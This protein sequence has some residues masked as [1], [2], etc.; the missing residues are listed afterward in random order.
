MKRIYTSIA[1]LALIMTSLVGV[2][3]AANATTLQVQ[4]A[5][6]GPDGKAMTLVFNHD[7][8]VGGA[9]ALVNIVTLRVNASV[10]S[11]SVSA[12]GAN[13]TVLLSDAAVPGATVTISF[14]NGGAYQLQKVGDPTV[15]WTGVPV[16]VTNN[17]VRL[18]L[19]GDTQVAISGQNELSATHPTYSNY[20]GN[21]N[22]DYY[23][24]VSDPVINSDNAKS[25]YVPY[26]NGSMDW[27]ISG[28]DDPTGSGVAIGSASD[29]Y[30]L[31]TQYSTTL[32]NTAQWQSVLVGNELYDP[33][34]HGQ[35]IMAASRTFTAGSTHYFLR[36][37]AAQ[38]YTPPV[39]PTAVLPVFTFASDSIT[40][41]TQPSWTGED[42]NSEDYFVYA[43]HGS[44]NEVSS[45][46]T[47]SSFMATIGGCYGLYTSASTLQSLVPATSLSNA[48]AIDSGSLVAYDPVAHGRNIT[49]QSA[50][51]Y[52]T[53]PYR[54]TTA[55]QYWMSNAGGGSSP[56]QVETTPYTGPVVNAPG[57]LKPVAPGE[58]L[59]LS[60]SN[61]SGVS[62]A[63]I[64]GSDAG[65]KVTASGE[66]EI[67]VPKGL[68]AGTYD[69]VITSDSGLLTI[70]DAIK[71]SESSVDAQTSP[72]DPSTRL[73]EDNT[74]KVYVFDVLGA[75]KIQIFFNGKEVAWINADDI[76][77]PK[78]TSDYLVRTLNLLSGKNI[79]EIYVDGK[80]VD[81][82][83]YTKVDD[84]SRI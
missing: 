31:N 80:R 45:P 77:D 38:F 40:F 63:T 15:F 79:I 12:S 11:K 36:F 58:K 42:S 48:Q 73:K 3:P 55:S 61:L 69:L 84:D 13:M 72:V 30:H 59:V 39:V 21:T 14:A 4:S 23:S 50:A 57:A 46:A 74:V 51:K 5:I 25:A 71:V 60:G 8:E 33:A 47:S 62:K 54:V 16:T 81:R 34:S 76:N 24:C 10:V 82:K 1:S 52:A 20:S 83:A 64:N 18:A 17:S 19:T 28:A 75:G 7:I 6:L 68:P 44:V 9:T 49:I 29:C 27:I 53:T 56:S 32:S 67:V 35:Y 66:I 2:G 43:C 26:V 78:L 37:S 70:Q 65:V 22:F 41:T